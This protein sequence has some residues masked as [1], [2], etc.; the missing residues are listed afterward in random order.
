MLL[1]VVVRGGV[2]SPAAF[3]PGYHDMDAATTALP[4]GPQEGPST[5]FGVSVALEPKP[6]I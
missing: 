4:Y 3:I 1:E 5:H 2:V 6:G